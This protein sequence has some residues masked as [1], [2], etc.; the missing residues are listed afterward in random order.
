MPPPDIGIGPET[1]FQSTLTAAIGEILTTG[2][3]SSQQ[4]ADWVRRLREAA[5][6][7]LTP[8]HILQSAL[9]DTMRAIYRSK[10]ERG[11]ILKFHPDV[12]RFMLASVAPKLHAE[13]DR[14][15]VASADLIKV[16]RAEAVEKTLHRFAGWA[17]SIPVGGSDITGRAEMKAEIR[18]PLASL[19][20]RERLVITDQGHKFV[21]NLNNILAQEAGALAVVWRSHWRQ[22][23]YNYRVD[24][25]ERDGRVY[26]L[27]DNW[28]RERGLVKPGEA[29]YYDQI[30]AVGQE[31]NC[32]CW[33]M[34]VYS[35]ARLPD[36]ML[37]E[38]GRE[39]LAKMRMAA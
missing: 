3:V 34:Y 28:A 18:K 38:R 5:I 26:M 10:I 2:Y 22:T 1:S 36:E 39:E 4:I 29:G 32:R 27:R 9:N 30:T 24:H 37:T 13:L 19:P 15:I 20:Y 7:T 35:L 25:K 11:A 17:T 12:P 33:A 8:P 6:R 21:A 23:H 31:V 16:N 14:R